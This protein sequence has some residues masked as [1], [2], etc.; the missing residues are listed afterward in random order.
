MMITWLTAVM[1]YL[2]YKLCQGLSKAHHEGA[3]E[4]IGALVAVV[5]L[6]IPTLYAVGWL[7]LPA[8]GLSAIP[9]GGR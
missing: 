8:W 7:L 9:L 3:A 4:Y 5:A 1:L 2:T 6:T